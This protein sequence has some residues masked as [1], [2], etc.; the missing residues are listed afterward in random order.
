MSFRYT[1]NSLQLQHNLLLKKVRAKTYKTT[2]SGN[3]CIYHS[4]FDSEG[5]DWGM[6]S[7]CNAAGRFTAAPTHGGAGCKSHK[8]QNTHQLT[9]CVYQSGT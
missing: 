1:R 8:K 7:G 2:K 5:E 3:C 6:E 9:L 4:E